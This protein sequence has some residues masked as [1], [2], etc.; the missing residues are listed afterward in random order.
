MRFSSSEGVLWVQGQLT[1]NSWLLYPTSK[2]TGGFAY[3]IWF[4]AK[5][6][7]FVMTMG[8][9]PD[10]HRDGYRWCR[11]WACAGAS[12]TA[13]SSKAGSYFALT[14]EALMAGG[15]L[16]ASAH[17]GPAW[18]EV[19]FSAHGIVFFDPFHYDVMA[20]ARIAAGVTI[21]TWIFGGSPSRSAW[22]RASTCSA[23]TSEQRHLRGRPHRADLRVRQL[24]QEQ[25]QPLAADAFIT[26]YL[27]GRRRQGAPACADDQRRRAAGKGEWSTP[28]G[29][30]SRP[31][32][33]VVEFS[34]TFTST[35]PATGVTRT[36]APAVQASSSHAPSAR[37][38]WR[39][40]TRRTSA[41]HR[42]HLAARRN[43]P[44]LPFVDSARPFG[45]FPVGVWARRRIRTRAV[46][47]GT[48]IE[49]L[50]ELDMVCSATPSAGGPEIPY[51]QVEIGSASRCPSRAAPPRSTSS[52]TPRNR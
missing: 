37:W 43:R 15:D 23:P 10:F 51:F 4:R 48:M 46:P 38:A 6:G 36:L 35:V 34:L 3:V 21:D 17:F 41:D 18:A 24:G 11:A 13:S 25:K 42:H 29:S 19:K 33:V 30:S 20:Y 9:P 50:S 47:S 12:A 8:L 52:A 14:S 5:S 32:V 44:A 22:A 31:F 2:L 1:D 27:G 40:W 7:E 26:K 39:R 45:R 49:A 28:D 16:R